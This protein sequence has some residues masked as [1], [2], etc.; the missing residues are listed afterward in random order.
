MKINKNF[1][2]NGFIILLLKIGNR[3]ILYRKG[4]IHQSLSSQSKQESMGSNVEKPL[5]QE[6]E[7]VLSNIRSVFPETWIYDSIDG[8]VTGY[9]YLLNYF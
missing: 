5:A 8:N 9:C 2:L 4:A 7:D 6:V 3:P 1:I